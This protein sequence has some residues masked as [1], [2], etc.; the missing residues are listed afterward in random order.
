MYLLPALWYRCVV[1]PA[2]GLYRSS[3]AHQCQHSPPSRP[4]HQHLRWAPRQGGNRNAK[5]HQR[6]SEG[7][8][9]NHYYHLRNAGLSRG[10]CRW[11]ALMPQYYESR[12]F[13]MPK[14]TLN[15]SLQTLCP[16]IFHLCLKL[17]PS[18]AKWACFTNSSKDC[19]SRTS[20][21]R[22]RTTYAATCTTRSTHVCLQAHVRQTFSSG[23]ATTASRT[24][25]MFIPP[26]SSA[27]Q[28]GMQALW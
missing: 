26:Q 21:L 24:S 7:R 14:S 15:T 22:W 19:L 5:T 9:A 16:A 6:P 1:T 2:R 18:V 23:R 28:P 12:F 3:H 8:I 11:S 13:P 17:G 4:S 25:Q 10:K 27:G 20:C